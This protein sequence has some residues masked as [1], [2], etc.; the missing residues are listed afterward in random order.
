MEGIWDV[1]RYRDVS[2]RIAR[3]KVNRH[4]YDIDMISSTVSYF[5]E[6]IHTEPFMKK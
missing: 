2:G 1:K 3:H 5:S 6:V 4:V